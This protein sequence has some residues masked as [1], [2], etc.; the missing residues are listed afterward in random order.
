MCLFPW[1]LITIKSLSIWCPIAEKSWVDT[2]Q[3]HSQEVALREKVA[4]IPTPMWTPWITDPS[5]QHKTLCSKHNRAPPSTYVILKGPSQLAQLP[6]L[7][8]ADCTTLRLV[9]R[10]IA[11][12]ALWTVCGGWSGER[13]WVSTSEVWGTKK[14]SHLQCVPYLSKEENKI[15]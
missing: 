15:L 9:S 2:T 12:C 1:L 11:A 13:H 5:G 7:L 14:L 8:Q 6:G 10:D 4:S 3:K